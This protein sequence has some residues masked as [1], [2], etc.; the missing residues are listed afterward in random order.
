[1]S[2]EKLTGAP[3]VA[4]GSF[5][6]Y[7][8]DSHFLHLFLNYEAARA[9]LGDL[10]ENG[11]KPPREPL[12]WIRLQ[13]RVVDAARAGQQQC[14]ESVFFKSIYPDEVIKKCRSILVHIENKTWPKTGEAEKILARMKEEL[15]E[16]IQYLAGIDKTTNYT[17]QSLLDDAH[18][19][20]G[21]L[22]SKTTQQ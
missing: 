16:M 10:P 11:K 19:L 6:G 20:C 5:I 8:S 22:V 14:P 15:E 4:Y 7:D 3:E 18:A 17:V 21:Q 12:E 2:N 9:T 1:M 13:S